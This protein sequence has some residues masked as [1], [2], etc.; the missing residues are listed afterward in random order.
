MSVETSPL[1]T[2]LPQLKRPLAQRPPEA[3][4]AVAWDAQQSV[5]AHLRALLGLGEWHE[6]LINNSTSTSLAHGLGRVPWGYR[7]YAQWPDGAGKA[8]GAI[9][10]PFPGPK[11]LWTRERIVLQAQT[12]PQHVRFLLF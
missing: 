9:Y 1:L 8:A 12:A 10:V 5:D 11:A 6:E 3:E 4:A 7:V 2:L